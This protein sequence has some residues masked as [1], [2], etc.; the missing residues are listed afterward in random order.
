MATYHFRNYYFAIGCYCK[1]KFYL[2]F[3]VGL[4]RNRRISRWLKLLHADLVPL[5]YCASHQH[6]C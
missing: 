5:R 4:P 3:D 1:L 6:A 2:A